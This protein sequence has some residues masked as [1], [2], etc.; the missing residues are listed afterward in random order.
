MPFQYPRNPLSDRPNPFQDG[1]NPFADDVVAAQLADDPYV[2]S[3]A[4]S[5]VSYQPGDHEVS[6]S[7]RGR[8]IIWL[9]TL[10]LL[11]TA[12]G[13]LSTAATFLYGF[14]LAADAALPSLV[15]GLVL[16]GAAWV[17]GRQDLQ[18]IRAGAMDSAG[19]N[20]T[21]LGQTFA[22]CGLLL[23]CLA[24]IAMLGRLILEALGEG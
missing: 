7:H 21:R 14:W 5:G 6:Y 23:S 24:F 15:A 9:A 13:L 8:L 18:A 10:G 3:P 2:A 12:L 16:C 11:G 17:L 19:F 4:P 20:R 1:R 22:G